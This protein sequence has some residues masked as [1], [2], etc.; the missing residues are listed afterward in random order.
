MTVKE[1]QVQF[2]CTKTPNHNRVLN[3]I[4]Q[5]A[6]VNNSHDKFSVSSSIFLWMHLHNRQ[7]CR[8]NCR[9]LSDNLNI[10]IH[11]RW[12]SSCCAQLF[13]LSVRFWMETTAEIQLYSY[14]VW[15]IL[16]GIGLWL[17]SFFGSETKT[18]SWWSV[19]V[20]HLPFVD[21]LVMVIATFGLNT[22]CG[23]LAILWR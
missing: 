3:L 2:C 14:N 7:Y 12:R 13:A 11:R 16:K 17:Q 4:A 5:N 21:W 23:N 1:F 10:G 18:Y 15:N 8:Q 9:L 19:T 20:T 22:I 6:S